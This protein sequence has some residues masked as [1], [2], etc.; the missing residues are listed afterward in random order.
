MVTASLSAANKAAFYW[1]W[2]MP[3]S[4]DQDLALVLRATASKECWMSVNGINR[5]M[6]RHPQWVK[7]RRVSRIGPI[8]NRYELSPE[9]VVALERDFGW[10]PQWWHTVAGR[11]H[12]Y[13]QIPFLELLYKVLPYMLQP[14]Q[15]GMVI[16]GIPAGY[17]DSQGNVV[18]AEYETAVLTDIQWVQGSV[19]RLVATY[20]ADGAD[21]EFFVPVVYYSSYRRPADVKDWQAVL[22][23][24]L[25]GDIW[26]GFPNPEVGEAI[27]QGAMPLPMLV[28]VPN[29]L[30][31]VKARETISWRPLF[32]V[33][34]VALDGNII[35]HFQTVS[36]R[37]SAVHPLPRPTELGDERE[38][39]RM[40]TRT[41][42]SAL[43]GPLEWRF[44]C[45]L[46]DYQGSTL[47][48]VR[49]GCGIG[50]K[51]ADQILKSFRKW[52]LVMVDGD[53]LYL[54]PQ[55]YIAYAAAEGVHVNRVRGR[56]GAFL[57]DPIRRREHAEHCWETAELA[58]L[59]KADGLP[60]YSGVHVAWV[61][62]EAGTEIVADLYVKVGV[63]SVAATP[64][65]REAVLAAFDST[66]DALAEFPDHVMELGLAAMAGDP[67]EAG[68]DVLTA[69]EALD[70]QDAQALFDLLPL[71][72]ELA[73]LKKWVDDKSV[74]VLIAIENERRAG[75]VAPP[76]DKI[77]PYMTLND[78]GLSVPWALVTSSE[79]VVEEFLRLGSS[80]PL[81]ATTW[82][83]IR[84]Q[85]FLTCWGTGRYLD[86]LP[87]TDPM[88]P[89]YFQYI[90]YINPIDIYASETSFRQWGLFSECRVGK[91][92]FEMP[93]DDEDVDSGF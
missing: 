29:E 71:L 68:S 62:S 17:P 38:L 26:E 57:T 86:P 79:A 61:Y 53:R 6:D 10:R 41:Y 84:S 3:Y 90:D 52:E 67:T 58:V 15:A 31:G 1:K 85:G 50:E 4:S 28:V 69:C 25:V 5:M 83:H 32:D 7:R 74:A 75:Y 27:A 45:W 70:E 54:G 33:G 43:S 24:V 49:A 81:V 34:I 91:N 23:E 19:I 9:G 37:W 56:Q 64:E 55:G 47:E 30:V 36:M 35:Q 63:L 46:H 92:P 11:Q 48:Q 66:M 93:D 8:A 76:A 22:D 12:M 14:Q 51:R 44:V 78:H 42:W 40:V 73:F 87:P 72:A 16:P 89:N 60:A 82:D 20:R 13:G 21:R 77:Q 39:D 88:D 18:Q 65:F 59:A 80:L 2:R